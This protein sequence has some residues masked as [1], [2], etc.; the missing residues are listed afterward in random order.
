MRLN[1]NH[2]HSG[3]NEPSLDVSDEL[4]LPLGE[5]QTKLVDL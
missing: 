3:S 4:P 2:A 1:R 5:K